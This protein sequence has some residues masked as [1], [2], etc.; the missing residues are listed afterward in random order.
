MNI[1]IFTMH[2]QS[3]TSNILSCKF[4]WIIDFYCELFGGKVTKKSQKIYDAERL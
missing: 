1:H 4:E 2:I 3:Y